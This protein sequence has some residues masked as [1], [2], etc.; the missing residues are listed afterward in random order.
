MSRLIDEKFI[1]LDT[2]NFVTYLKEDRVKF[3]RL[4]WVPVEFPE[5]S[6]VRCNQCHNQFNTGYIH[7]RE[8]PRLFLCRQCIEI[9]KRA[10]EFKKKKPVPE[11]V[12]K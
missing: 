9:N 6:N 3:D 2:Y 11:L 10:H 1:W 7:P 5:D 4:A 12:A 8:N